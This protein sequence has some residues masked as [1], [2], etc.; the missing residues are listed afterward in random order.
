MTTQTLLSSLRTASLVVAA[1]AASVAADAASAAPAMPSNIQV[2]PGPRA[3]N[4]QPIPP[5]RTGM[6][7]LNPQPIPPGRAEAT[8][9][10]ATAGGKPVFNAARINPA[11]I[12]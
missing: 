12:R 9:A 1:A 5:G 7:A 10:A 4:P 3:L 2:Q 6:V 8:G 11:P